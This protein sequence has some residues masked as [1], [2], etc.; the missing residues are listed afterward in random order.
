MAGYIVFA[1]GTISAAGMLAVWLYR[2]LAERRAR[3]NRRW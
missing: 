2:R 3:G 1:I